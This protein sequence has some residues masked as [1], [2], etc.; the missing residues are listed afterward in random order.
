MPSDAAAAQNLRQ[1]CEAASSAIPRV[2]AVND[3]TLWTGPAANRFR[4][5]LDELRILANRAIGAA[6]VAA[7]QLEAAVA[8][9]AA[10]GTG[11]APGGD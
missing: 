1:G 7:E 8:A 9:A 3:P 11:T 6:R 5:E 2:L 10:A 4:D